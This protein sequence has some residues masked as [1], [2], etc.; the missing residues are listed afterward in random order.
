[1]DK[2]SIKG[3]IQILTSQIKNHKPIREIHIISRQY[4]KVH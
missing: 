2:E 4:Y 1:M 3:K